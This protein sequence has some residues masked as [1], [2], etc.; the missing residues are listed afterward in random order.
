MNHISIIG[1]GIVG[2]SS[3]YYLH[4][5]GYKV[6]VFDKGDL[7][8][9]CSYGNAGYVCPSHFV[10]L[11]APGIIWQGIKWMFNP[12]SPFYVKPSLNKALIN[13]GFKFMQSANPQHVENSAVPLRDISL[14][15]QKLFEEWEASALLT[16]ATSVRVCLRFSK[17]KPLLPTH[18]IPSKKHMN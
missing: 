10:P 9:N 6:T 15:S 16:L 3:A 12:L 11:A 18:I 14:L 4:E 1:G 2:L 13:W 17:Q 7:S 5:A 8:D